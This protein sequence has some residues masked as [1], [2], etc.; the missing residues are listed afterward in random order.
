MSCEG[1][2]VLGDPLKGCMVP[3]R[4]SVGHSTHCVHSQHTGQVNHMARSN[5]QHVYFS[6]S[7]GR[8][9][10]VTGNSKDTHPHKRKGRENN[11]D[12]DTSSHHVLI[13]SGGHNKLPQLGWP[14]QH[15]FTVS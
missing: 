12:G 7:V 9:P 13:S 3:L 14:E 6:T 1:V 10:Q 11:E 5:S 8:A 4:A 2:G 15:G